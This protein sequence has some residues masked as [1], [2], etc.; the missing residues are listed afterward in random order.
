MV[1][2]HK[3]LYGPGPYGPGPY[4]RAKIAQ[5][6]ILL[7]SYIGLRT[8]F[9][10]LLQNTCTAQITFIEYCS[11]FNVTFLWKSYCLKGEWE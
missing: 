2:D 7:Q 8:F 10:L 6:Q 5:K 9:S 11:D 4:C 3:I 1:Q